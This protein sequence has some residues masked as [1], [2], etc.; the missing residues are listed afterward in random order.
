MTSEPQRPELLKL[1]ADERQR[2]ADTHR[3]SAELHQRGR[4]A[5]LDGVPMSWMMTWPGGYPI[6]AERAQGARVVDVDGN[7]FVDFC[8][9]DTGAMAGHS[10][11]ATS[12]A[13]AHQSERGNTMMLPTE[14]SV[15]VA[16]ELARR[17]GVP[18]WQFQ[19]SATD[20]N[21]N[22]LR[23]ARGIT[24]RSKLLMMNR[25]YHGTVDDTL[26]VLS[27]DGAVVRR[28]TSLG[29]PIDPAMTT[30]VV[31]F[32]DTSGLEVA[33]AEGDVAC[34][35]TE[36]V[37]SGHGFVAP[38]PGYHDTLRGL[39]RNAGVVLIIDETH[40]ICAGP[41]GITAQMGLEPDIITTGKVI[42]GGVPIGALG[43]SAEVAERLHQTATLPLTGVTGLGGTLAGNALS[44]AAAR[45][46]LSEVL[47]ADSYARMTA[48]GE[49]A[50]AGLTNQMHRVGVPWHALG[51][52]SR[53]EYCFR[54]TPP[55]NGS[56]A[57]AARDHS[58]EA[59]IHLFSLNNGV[60]VVP[61]HNLAMISAATTAD[62]VDRY[63]EV[64]G[65]AL[66]VLG[67]HGILVNHDTETELS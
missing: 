9:G 60:L 46:T 56:E 59:F 15:W 49:R 55:R 29:A 61:F 39:T 26:A 44:L 28:P 7:E 45:A 53:V 13:L 33:L 18:L 23:I 54:A 47:T 41:G 32:N 65:N 48:L 37:L 1:L 57:M 38:E 51:F 2:F 52:G 35:L 10:P 25:T 20:A 4:A 8:L 21:R 67:R 14:D 66:D 3:R 16:E 36:P 22:A 27:D 50:V 11:A 5:L 12:R 30:R 64:F 62:D 58:L 6:F 63:V 43:L 17:F 40:M 19:L 24:G 42:A 34:V 31:E